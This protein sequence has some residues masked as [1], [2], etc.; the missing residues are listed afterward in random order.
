MGTQTSSLA[1][2]Y[3]GISSHRLRYGDSNKKKM[4]IGPNFSTLPEMR[5]ALSPSATNN[6]ALPQTLT[7]KLEVEVEA[8]VKLPHVR[9]VLTLSTDSQSPYARY[10]LKV[11]IIG[12]RPKR[13]ILN[14]DSGKA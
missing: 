12:E 13:K 2:I 11:D 6:L 4:V 8:G 5:E 9:I 3:Q 7:P 14:V 10:K 1:G